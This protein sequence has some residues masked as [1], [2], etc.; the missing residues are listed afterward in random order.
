MSDASSQRRDRGPDTRG[1]AVS[2]EAGSGRRAFLIGTIGTL[3]AG[4]SSNGRTTRPLPSPSFA[5]RPA[6]LP[7]DPPR[8]PIVMNPSPSAVFPGVV[9]RVT[10]AGGAAVPSLMNR[11][12]PIRHVTVHHD[13]MLFVGSSESDGR[14]RLESIRRAH[15]EKGWG[16]IGYHFAID[17]QGR[18]YEGRPLSWQGAHVRDHNEGNIGIVLLGNFEVQ[19][20]TAAQ[21]AA[22]QRHVAVVT[23]RFRVPATSIHSHREWP[24]AATLCP[25][26]RLQGRID[27]MR[28]RGALV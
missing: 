27:E 28:R 7:A 26:R 21:L 14:A 19:D 11:M 17:R 18:I 13:A 25:G 1:R 3:L 6:P 2:A 10:W 16:D 24:G 15:R 12:L 8:G 20:P 5:A 9:P 23:D 22:M 4:C